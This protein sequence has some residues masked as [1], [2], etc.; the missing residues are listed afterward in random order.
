MREMSVRR[1]CRVVAVLTVAFVVS[2]ATSSAGASLP[3]NAQIR[4]GPR[5]DVTAFRRSVATRYQVEL[6]RIVTA[7]IDRDGDLDVL[8]TTDYGFTV[9][10]NDG[11]GRLTWQAPSPSPTLDGR[12]PATTWRDHDRRRD[13][14][15]QDDVPSVPVPTPYAHAPPALVARSTVP[16]G[17]FPRID[18]RYRPSSPRGPPIS[19]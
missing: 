8:A 17:A 12:S 18:L 9:W 5:I 13:E 11:S 16:F 4:V 15:L 6:R 19:R 14:S 3:P 1:A 7:D 2:A 10:L